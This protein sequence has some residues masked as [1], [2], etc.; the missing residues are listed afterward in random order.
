MTTLLHSVRSLS[1]VYRGDRYPAVYTLGRRRIA[2]GPLRGGVLHNPRSVRPTVA[3][4]GRTY[5]V[6]VVTP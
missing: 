2:W 1:I 3:L 4:G 5:P 6:G